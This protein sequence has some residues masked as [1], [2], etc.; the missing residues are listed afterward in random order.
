[1]SWG[2]EHEGKED[3]EE[4]GG[5]NYEGCE[6]ASAQA[7]KETGDEALRARESWRLGAALAEAEK[8]EAAHTLFQVRAH[9]WYRCGAR[10]C[11]MSNAS[12]L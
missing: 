8:F 2:A 3:E 9:H 10:C 5:I 1:M 4:E 7:A 11:I 6:V 12:L